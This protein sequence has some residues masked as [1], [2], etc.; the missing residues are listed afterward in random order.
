MKEKKKA[1]VLLVVI[2]VLATIMT[3]V[4]SVSF[5]SISETQ[6]SKL[7]EENQKALAAAEAA[8]ERALAENQ[9]VVLGSGS[10]ADFSEFSGQATVEE[11]STTN[12][13]SP[14]VKKDDGYTFYLGSY[15][16]ET[17]IIGQ[18]VANNLEIC[19]QGQDLVKP[20]VEITL[21]KETSVKKYVYDSEKRINNASNPSTICNNSN[22]QYSLIIPGSDIGTDGKILYIRVLYKATKLYFSSS[23]DL[24]I[25]G[26]IVSSQ[27]ST[28]TGVSKKIIL[29]QSHPQIPASFFA[30]SF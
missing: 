19:Y 6:I 30:T 20:A 2:M 27:A 28:E 9:T 26:R 29:F 1:Q 10:L 13:T 4:L 18:S 3:I 8:L 16:R 21:L 22:F 23:L 25:Q 7:E 24:P 15:N 11:I 12:F 17:G 5:Q 14:L